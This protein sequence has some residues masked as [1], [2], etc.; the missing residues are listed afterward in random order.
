LEA[1]LQKIYSDFNLIVKKER[2]GKEFIHDR[3]IITDKLAISMGRG[4]GLLSKEISSPEDLLLD[5]NI[6]CC[7]EHGKIEAAVRSLPDL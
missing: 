7:S 4:V 2:Q 3:Y 1:D 6:A 5:F